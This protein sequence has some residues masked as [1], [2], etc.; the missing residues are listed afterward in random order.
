MFLSRCFFTLIE[1]A[2]ELQ[3]PYASATPLFDGDL[4]KCGN[5]GLNS[6]ED[7]ERGGAVSDSIIPRPTAELLHA[8]ARLSVK[9]REVLE[10]LREF[11]EGARVDELGDAL[12]MHVNTI[13]GHLDELIKD[14]VVFSTSAAAG[15]RGRPRQVYFARSP[16]Q[17]RVA[18]EYIPLVEVL[19]QLLPDSDV[20]TAREA[21][22]AWAR[23]AAAVLPPESRIGELLSRLRE[24]G[25]DPKLRDGGNEVGLYA[26]PFIAVGG[27][28]PAPM[29]CAMHAGYLQEV[30]ASDA[31]SLVPFDRPGQCGVHFSKNPGDDPGI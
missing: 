11:P 2:R 1:S 28:R 5:D 3:V 17:D 16:R 18:V 15:G 22:R 20:N 24:M 27:Q 25:F 23:H 10:A 13:R 26:C 14:G 12:G 29:I 9:Q 8:A 19:A 7:G 6:V 31:V 4:V 21:G 30:C